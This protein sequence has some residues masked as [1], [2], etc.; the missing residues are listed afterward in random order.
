MPKNPNLNSGKPWS[1]MDTEDLR[2]FALGGATAAETATFLCRDVDETSAKARELGL[3]LARGL[4][5][6]RR[7]AD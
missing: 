5:P 3:Q 6:S 7:E 4:E 1:E 2:S